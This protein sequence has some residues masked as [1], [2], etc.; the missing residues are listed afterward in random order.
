MTTNNQQFE[1]TMKQFLSNPIVYSNLMNI[2]EIK[3][4]EIESSKTETIDPLTLKDPLKDTAFNI[5]KLTNQPMLPILAVLYEKCL[6]KD[7]F[8]ELCNQII[9]FNDEKINEIFLN[10]FGQN[11]TDELISKMNFKVLQFIIKSEST[12]MS[13]LELFNMI[14]KA[15]ITSSN[16][17]E[18]LKCINIASIGAENIMKIV[19]K[20]GLIDKDTCLQ[21]VADSFD[22][23]KC[24]HR[25]INKNPLVC[26]GLYNSTHVG[27]SKFTG[28]D[29]NNINPAMVEK[30][31]SEYKK[32]DGFITLN[33][34]SFNELNSSYREIRAGSYNIRFNDRGLVR[35]SS[36]NNDCESGTVCK[37]SFYQDL[38]LQNS[39][40][41]ISISNTSAASTKAMFSF[42]IKNN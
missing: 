26:V 29:L 38:F 27:Y 20:S 6:D 16:V 30:F 31:N 24:I 18:L 37:I 12:P 33:K 22:P 3:E 4:K 23:T 36:I 7:N 5:I 8:I 32:H 41:I 19:Y 21:A 40:S 13:E 28:D 25:N 35:L 14:T 17:Q 39:E 11:I 1:E 10:F 42:F 15:N 34:I 9:D 2:I